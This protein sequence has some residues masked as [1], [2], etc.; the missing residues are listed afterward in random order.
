MTFDK[1]DEKV[2]N[3]TFGFG[4]LALLF[5]LV[6]FSL[7]GLYL[8]KVL[9]KE[10]GERQPAWFLCKPNYW[11]CC[12]QRRPKNNQIGDKNDDSEFETQYLAK[13]YYEPNLEEV[14]QNNECLRVHG[15]VKEYSNGFKAVKGLNL[16]IYD[17]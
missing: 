10:F 12:R 3:Y 16:K 17:N 1:I 4:L 14:V 6:F 9:P 8:E 13:Q 11:S 15:L 2:G 5:D 7:L